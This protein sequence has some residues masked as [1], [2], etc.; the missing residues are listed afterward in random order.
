V[1]GLA[2]SNADGSITVGSRTV[3]DG[4]LRAIRAPVVAGGVCPPLRM[5]GTSRQAMVNQRFVELH[6]PNQ[7]LVGRTLDMVQAGPGATY[8]I[9]GIVGTMAE[10]GPA[11]SPLPFVYT[12]SQPGWWPDP[13]YVVRTADARALA[14]DLR[15]I[16]NR[17]DATRAIFGLR[18]LGDVVDGAFDQ[19]KL[20]AA[21]LA[22]FASAALAMAG[23]GL[24]SLFMLVVSDRTRE[25]AVRLAIGASPGEMSRLIAAAAGRLLAGGLVLGIVLT[26]AADRVLR[27]LLFGIT[28]FDA[29]AL[30]AST[31]IIAAVAMAAVA[32]PAL[33]AARVA[34]IDALRGE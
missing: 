20:D 9:V 11:V 12:C 10:D 8:T 18:P 16:V 25:I 21:M 2:G 17:I 31:A 29:G 7:N 33:R 23:V 6:A 4:Y 5:D 26:V 28:S 34:P 14:A 27:G 32:A 15:Q 3:T 13:E 19:P 22:S 1:S 24:Y 30:A